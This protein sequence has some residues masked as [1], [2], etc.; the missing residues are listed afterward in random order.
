MNRMAMA[1]IAP[2]LWPEISMRKF[3]GS[4]VQA[5]RMATR[6]PCQKQ[7]MKGRPSST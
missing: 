4:R 1:I 2:S 6:R 7:A 5:A 3:A